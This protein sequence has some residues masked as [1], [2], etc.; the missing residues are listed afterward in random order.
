MQADRIKAHRAM[1]RSLT[2]AAMKVVSIVNRDKDHIPPISTSDQNPF[3]YKVTVNPKQEGSR[4]VS[5][6]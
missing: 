2:K 6:W 3:P 5:G 1:E 4:G